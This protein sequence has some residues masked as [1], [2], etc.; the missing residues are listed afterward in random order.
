MTDVCY[1]SDDD[2]FQIA[3]D[4]E[5][6]FDEDDEDVTSVSK[7]V[8]SENKNATNKRTKNVEETY[9]KLTPH[10]VRAMSINRC[11]DSQESIEMMRSRC[12][13]GAARRVS[14]TAFTY[15]CFPHY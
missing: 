2:D 12:F 7:K 5:S 15:L 1:M 3:E 8:L 9:Q 13:R 14:P 10:E 6:D 11:E 4:I